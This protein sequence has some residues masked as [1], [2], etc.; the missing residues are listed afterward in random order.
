MNFDLIRRLKSKELSLLTI[1]KAISRPLIISQLTSARD[2]NLSLRIFF[3]FFFCSNPSLS[4]Q[5][6]HQH[7]EANMSEHDNDTWIASYSSFFTCE[8]IY[9][10][11]YV[12]HRDLPTSQHR[13][14]RNIH[15]AEKHSIRARHVYETHRDMRM[16]TTTTDRVVHI[17]ISIKRRA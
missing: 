16:C 10:Y 8:F 15:K 9:I 14:A 13:H 7:R 1:F 11:T 4:K 2:S 5:F 12:V 3:F 17:Y 6:P